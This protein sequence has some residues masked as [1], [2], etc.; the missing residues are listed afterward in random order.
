M[1]VCTVVFRSLLAL[2]DERDVARALIAIYF[3]IFCPVD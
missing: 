1:S 2:C 3:Y